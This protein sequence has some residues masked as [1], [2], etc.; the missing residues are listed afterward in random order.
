MN[1]AKLTLSLF[2]LFLLL[3]VTTAQRRRT[4]PKPATSQPT[5]AATPQPTPAPTTNASSPAVAVVND[6]TISASDIEAEVNE[7]VMQDADPYLRDYYGDP[8]KAI[9]EARLRAVDARL[10]S[11]LISAEAKKRG[12][13]SAAILEAEVSSRVTPPTD[14]EIRAAYDANRD[15]L[16]SAGLESVRPQLI[17]FIRGQRTQD[18]Y[19]ALVNRLKMTNVVTRNADINASNLAPGT[20]IAAVNGNPLRIETINERMKAYA[21]KMDMRLYAIRKGRCPNRNIAWKNPI[22]ICSSHVCR[23]MVGKKNKVV[24]LVR[25]HVGDGASHGVSAEDH[26]GIRE[27]QPVACR[28]LRGNP[29]G[30]SL[31]QPAGRQL[32][33]VFD[34]QFSAA[35]A[36]QPIHYFARGIGGA[37]VDGDDFVIR[38]VERKQGTQRLFDFGLFVTRR[39]NNGHARQTTGNP[40]NRFRGKVP[41]VFRDYRN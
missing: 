5:P 38:I 33:N 25:F 36:F 34:A 12:K 27:Q 23:I 18:L 28:L 29:H 10:A 9:R 20:V 32:A 26:V 37:V 21:Y 1:L 6:L 11:M 4:T 31:T 14:Q 17:S 16:G 2:I 7:K 35:F 40:L 3:G 24:G 15:Q 19:A 30:M 22:I 41:F 13:T 39:H 8:A